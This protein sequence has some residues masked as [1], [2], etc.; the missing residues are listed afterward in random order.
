MKFDHM[1]FVSVMYT[2]LG[3]AVVLMFMDQPK[4]WTYILLGAAVVSGLI[5][6]VMQGIA[7]KKM[8][9]ERDMNKK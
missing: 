3:F 7:K 2:F 4:L 9:K 6:N 8:Q 5:G 1:F